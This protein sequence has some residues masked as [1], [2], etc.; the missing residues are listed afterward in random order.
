MYEKLIEI[1]RTKGLTKSGEALKIC[2]IWPSVANASV[3]NTS[4]S[5]PVE[6]ASLVVQLMHTLLLQEQFLPPK[7][8][9]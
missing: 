9:R 6:D 8:Q 4:L 1:E 3:I 7:F 5:F 2:C